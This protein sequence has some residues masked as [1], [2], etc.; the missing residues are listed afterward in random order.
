MI[1]TGAVYG[2]GD[3]HLNH[4]GEDFDF[5]LM[6]A[7]QLFSKFPKSLLMWIL[8]GVKTPRG[9]KTISGAT[10]RNCP[11]QGARRAFDFFLKK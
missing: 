7:I 1:F 8:T 11:S 9:W 4:T 10:P 3:E 2:F 5:I 6:S